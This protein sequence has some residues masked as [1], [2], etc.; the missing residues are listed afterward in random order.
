MRWKCFV[1]YDGTDFEGWQSQPNGNTI[2]DYLE[3]RLSF[4]CERPIRIHGSG[5]TDSGVH[6]T[7]QVFHF[8]HDWRHGPI[9][10]VRALRT[11]LPEGIQVF[12]IEPAKE[13]FHARFS[14]INKRYIY[15]FYEGWAPPFELRYVHSLKN[16][17]L[18]IEAMNE[19]ARRLIGTHDFTAF[20]ANRGDESEEDPV[21]ELRVL[22]MSREGPRVTLETEGSGYLY[23]MV[24]SLAGC[25]QDVGIGKLTA[26]DVE[27]ILHSRNR[28]ALVQT[29]PA[30]GLT[31]ERVDYPGD[32]AT[33]D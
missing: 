9:K 1:A 23:K 15:R 31:L 13:D 7:G 3:R 16:F 4:L 21:K 5:R 24:R 18:D 29:A 33:G 17:R 20:A 25:L 6:A 14:A 30:R 27:S 26:N 2:Q 32:E 28:T 11:G 12:A 22:Q 19:A 8:D 10:L